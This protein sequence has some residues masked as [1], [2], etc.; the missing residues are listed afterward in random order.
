MHNIYDKLVRISI[1]KD[2]STFEPITIKFSDIPK[3]VCSENIMYSPVQFVD[4]KRKSANFTKLADILILDFD[5]GWNQEH[6]DLFNNYIG[7]KV[8]TKSH[9]KL[10]NDIICERYRIILLLDRSIN[11]D[12]REYRRL[13]KHIMR[14][15]NLD[16]DTS[17][18][19]AARFY[20][21][22]KQP[23]ENCIKLKGTKFFEWQ[24]FSYKDVQYASLIKEQ[25]EIDVSKYKHIDVSFL[26]TLQHS[27]RYQCPLCHL[28]GLDKRKHHLG[29]NTE[30]GYPTCFYD[31]NHSKI[32]RRLYKL[33]KY[34]TVLD[35]IEEISDMVREKCTEDLI[36]IAKYNPKPT[37]YTE[38]VRVLYDKA[39]DLIETDTFVDLD[40]ETFCE[41]Y[42][43]ETLEE[44][45]ARLSKDY[46]YI[47]GAYTRKCDSYKNIA[48]DTFKNKIRIITLGGGGAVCP[49]D[50]Y[51]VT[52]E[53]KQRILNI[54]KNKIV[55]GHNIKFD[56]KS[57][58]ASYGE[59]YCPSYCF[60]TM[61]ASKMIHM[62]LDPEEQQ[63]GHSLASTA[64]RFLDYT[65]DK[66]VEHSWGNDNLSPRQ[67]E[68]ASSDVKVIRPIFKEQV[69]QFKQIYGKFD[70]E[71]YDINEL[72]FLG[73]LVDEH[74]ILA[75]EMQTLLEVIRIEF[76]GIKTNIPMMEK[77]ID[78]YNDCIDKTDAELGI[79]C[80]SAKQCVEFLKKYV[81]PNIEQSDKSTLSSYADKFPI[82]QKIIDA[83]AYRTRKGL[84]ESMSDTS[85]HPYDNRVHPNFNQLLSTGRF[86][87]SNP[88][89]QQIPADIKNDI[90]S[91]DEDGIVY[92]TDYAAV[93]LRLVTVVSG[94]PL[95]LEAYKQNKDM[96]YLTASL[97]FH[98]EIP[99]TPEEKED[100]ER[101]P[102]T[103]F[104]QKWQRSFA[105]GMN[106]GLI[107][108]LHW[109]TFAAS[110]IKQ[111]LGMT[112]E[113]A[114]A[115]YDKFF[116]T[117]KGIKNMISRAKKTFIDGE[118]VN[119]TRWIKNK[120]GYLC[121]VVRPTA[122]YTTCKTLLGRIIAI[123]GERKMMNYPVQGSGADTI[124]LAICKLGYNTRKDTTSHRT[125]NLV[126]DDTIG[127]SKVRDFD[128]NSKYFRGALEW[129]INFILRKKFYTPVDQDFCILSMFGEEVFLEKARTL[130][131]INEKLIDTMKHDYSLLQEYQ[132]L[133]DIDNVN[134]YTKKLNT[135]YKILNKLK[136]YLNN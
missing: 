16:S 1:G 26:D 128:I 110:V 108:G 7:W 42:V 23:I 127:Q 99:K 106:F 60:D 20:Y 63:I 21:S 58:M 40:I 130:E 98:K 47:K 88:N 70:T 118:D 133:N 82:V 73:P 9:M 93:E 59:E 2:F 56:I 122:F 114:H 62:A 97:L 87:C 117:Y 36:K 53:Q 125:I 41:E 132:S 85:I 43:A 104:V 13:Y 51:Y 35:E 37:N 46:K 135:Q 5:E 116:D 120:H 129:A 94:D 44:C 123:D 50:M 48:L 49:F 55:I 103:R 95:M 107:Y 101:N 34:G 3:L 131:E 79:N 31:E 75:L 69:K 92:D 45:E 65:M 38:D 71:N 96:H 81:D 18:V 68:Y 29:F 115:Y 72:R 76:T 22:A 67:L 105:K 32:L 8:P 25:E 136:E 80:G 111:G 64:F 33:Y 27:K 124:K 126:H 121:R 4:N 28:E 77:K 112:E 52:D 100:A 54:V 109:T 134:K 102:N 39:L 30:D 66:E 57:I 84:M 10:K 78:F 113:E 86:S 19:D 11:L 74:P 15:L 90:Y 61:I 89:M 14:D 12:Y 91:S 119:V 83:K 17:C 24:K 6:E